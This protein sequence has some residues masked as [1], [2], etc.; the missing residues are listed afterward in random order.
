MTRSDPAREALV[1][2]G[3]TPLEAEIYRFLL[4]ESPATGH[5]IARG[6]GKANANVYQALD[7][8]AGKSAVEVEEGRSRR[9]RPVPVD[10]LLDDMGRRFEHHRERAR[11]SLESLPGPLPDGGIYRLE[12]RDA[13]LDRARHVIDEARAQVMIDA[14]P[15]P[16]QA[17][18]PDLDTAV[19]RGVRVMVKA[20]AEVATDG[21][22]AVVAPDSERVRRRWPVQWLNLVVDSQRLLICAFDADGEEVL[23][24]LW[25]ENPYLAFLFDG[26]LA[27]EIAFTAVRAASEAGGAELADSVE[28]GSSL[29][30]SETP[31][32]HRLRRLLGLEAAASTSVQENPS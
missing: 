22:E 25:S 31:G 23:E 30:G 10:E 7:S 8:L 2:L 32:F 6:I 12:G 15:R 13:V 5:R 3:L 27:H 18:R 14:F 11:R 26:S 4:T 24:A 9:Y 20:Y 16:L 21:L 28:W 19:G 1:A 17:L 29:L